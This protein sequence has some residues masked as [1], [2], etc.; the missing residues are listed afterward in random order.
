MDQN[1]ILVLDD[2]SE[3]CE[4]LS[5]L[6][7]EENFKVE[8]FLKAQAALEELKLVKYDLILL[9]LNMPGMPGFEF[10]KKL[11][12]IAG[13]APPVVVMTAQEKVKICHNLVKAIIL[14]PFDLDDLVMVVREQV[15]LAGPLT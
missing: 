11:P 5:L 15:A 2:N 4:L 12:E 10:L 14:K 1:K 13:Y 6:L 9:D 3:I 8:C 7:T